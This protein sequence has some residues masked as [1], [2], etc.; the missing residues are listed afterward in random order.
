MRLK[1]LTIVSM[2]A[3]ILCAALA[4]AIVYGFART[5]Y[6]LLAFV[7]PVIIACIFVYRHTA[8][9]RALQALLTALGAILVGLI[10]IYGVYQYTMTKGYEPLIRFA[11]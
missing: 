10:I 5:P 6:A 2:L 11:P 8:R 7:P 3:G 4:L 9:R 1:L